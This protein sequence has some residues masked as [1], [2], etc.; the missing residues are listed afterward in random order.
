MDEHVMPAESDALAGVTGIE[1]ELGPGAT[2]RL[3]LPRAIEE[4]MAAE[5]IEAQPMPRGAGE[6]VLVVEDNAGMRRIVQR[7]LRDLGYQVLDSERAAAAL[8]ILQREP[9]DLLL[10][11]IVMPGELDGVE[12][13]RIARE[14][15]PSLKV[16]LT[17]GFPQARVDD[18][19]EQ[20]AGLRLLSKPYHKEELAAALRAM[21]DG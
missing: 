18:N 6:T 21:L 16:V 9:V 3:Y 15:W 20:L 7:Q 17:S 8:E 4:A 11:D 13:A 1:S 14:R 10:T 5:T 19:G 12:L 2:F